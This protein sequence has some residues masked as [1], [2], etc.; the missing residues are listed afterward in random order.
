M[1]HWVQYQITA[2]TASHRHGDYK[3]HM[4]RTDHSR[5]PCGIGPGPSSRPFYRNWWNVRESANPHGSFAGRFQHSRS[6]RSPAGKITRPTSRFKIPREIT[7]IPSSR[8]R[9]ITALRPANT[10]CTWASS[11]PATMLTSTPPP[12]PTVNWTMKQATTRRRLTPGCEE[13]GRAPR[14]SACACIPQDIL[15]LFFFPSPRI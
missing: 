8:T 6:P 1:P 11:P 10:P 14:I 9:S 7:T 3:R 4:R 2:L 13:P 15:F 5:W 12:V